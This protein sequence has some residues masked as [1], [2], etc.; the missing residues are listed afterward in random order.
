MLL[1]QKRKIC[2]VG[3]AAS[4]SASRQYSTTEWTTCWSASSARSDFIGRRPRQL[5]SLPARSRHRHHEDGYTGYCSDDTRTRRKPAKTSSSCDCRSV[6]AIDYCKLHG[7]HRFTSNTIQALLAR[8]LL[9]ILHIYYGRITSFR[10][11]VDNNIATTIAFR[12]TRHRY[13]S[14]QAYKV[15]TSA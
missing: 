8:R 10:P 2:A 7:L 5:S 12:H 13:H 4:S 3:E 6:V 11:A 1:T 15:A 9:G 14:Y